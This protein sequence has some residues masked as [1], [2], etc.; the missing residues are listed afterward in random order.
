MTIESIDDRTE[1]AGQPVPPDFERHLLADIPVHEV[2]RYVNRKVLLRRYLGIKGDALK[3]K[4]DAGEKAAELEAFVDAF[5]DEAVAQRWI[6]AAAVY[7]FFPAWREG[8][9]LVLLDPVDPSSEIE[10]FTFPETRSLRRG[11]ILDALGPGPGAVALFVVTAGLGVREHATR[12]KDEGE[13]LRSH[14]LYSLSMVLAEGLTEMIHGKL[15][16]LWG[17]ADPPGTKP[18]DLHKGR[19]RGRRISFG[20]RGCPPLEDQAKLFRLMGP[21]DVGIGLT[22]SFMM[23]P[24]A[25]VSAVVFRD[26]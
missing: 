20:Y 23:N 9:D 16:A 12:L 1:S 14:V 6:G 21:E 2:Y 25:S 24:E 10:R 22:E 11:P 4:G 5:F 18:T 26:E 19:Y 8:Y 3:K 7:R 17:I 13:Y 15:R